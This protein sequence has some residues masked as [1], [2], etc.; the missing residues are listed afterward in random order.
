MLYFWGKC[1]RLSHV[2]A[3][4]HFINPNSSEYNLEKETKQF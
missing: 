3:V 1:Y 4:P 2:T